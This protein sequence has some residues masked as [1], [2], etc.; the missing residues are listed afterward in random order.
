MKK[1]ISIIISILCVLSLVGCGKKEKYEIEILVPA[2][3]TEEF[4]F[5]DEEICPTGNT[6]KIWSGAG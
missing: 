3:S 2:G 5:S 6:I 4:V 1:Y